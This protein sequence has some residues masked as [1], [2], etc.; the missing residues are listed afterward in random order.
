VFNRGTGV[1]YNVTFPGGP[2]LDPPPNYSIDYLRVH[3]NDVTFA[4]N[5]SAS[6]SAPSLTVANGGVSIVV[7]ENAGDVAILTT[8]LSSLSATQ[9][10]IGRAAGANGTL[11]VTAGTFSLIHPLEVGY[12]GTGTLNITGGSVSDSTGYIGRFTG[13]TG[14]ATVSGAAST[15]TNSDEIQV[16]VDGTGTLRI[17]AGGS[18]TD[19]YGYVGL[20]PGSMGAATVTGAGSSWT[21]TEDFY[22]GYRGTGTLTI[23]AGGSVSDVFGVVGYDLGS[24]GTATVTGAGS[25]WTNSLALIVDYS[26]TLRIEAGGSVSS[27][28]GEVR[29]GA[30]ATVN[31]IGSTWTNSGNLT[32]GN[33][34]TGTLTIEAGGSVSNQDGRVGKALFFTGTVTVSGIGST[35]TNSG[36]LAVGDSGRGTLTIE[37]GGSVSNQDGYVG[38]FESSTGTATVTG[39][40]ST[41]TNSGSLTVGRFGTGTLR[42]E[43]GGS[44][45][46]INSVIA[47]SGTSSAGTV[48]VTGVG[49]T[50][51]T[52]G[53]LSVGS[54]S[55]ADG[56]GSL[57]VETG[58]MVNIVQNLVLRSTGMVNLHGGQI[59]LTSSGSELIFSGGAFNFSLGTLRFATSQAI[60]F[61]SSI[62][63]ALGGEPRLRVGQHLE[64]DGTL[65]LDAPFQIDGGHLEV[66]SLA[67]NSDLLFTAGVLEVRGGSITGSTSLVVPASG[68]LRTSGVHSF[69]VTG[70]AGSTIT[71]TGNL[72]LGDAAAVNGFGTQGTVQVGANTLTLLDA[73]DVVFDSLALATLGSGAS[74]GAL[75]AANGLTLD[76]GG[77]I[78]G[79]G[80]VSTPN[81]AV[82][83]LINNGHITGNSP[84]QPITLPGYVKGVGTL[85]NVNLTGTF[86]PG[87]SPTT[88]MV[89]NLAFAPTST[90]IMEIGG[91]SAGSQYDQLIAFGN[92]FFDGNLQISLINGF[93]PALG[94]AFNIFDWQ[95][96]SGTFDTINLPTLSSSLA[97]DTSQLYI[98]GTLRIAS[99]DLPGDF[100]H[101]GKVD[102]ADY[103]AWR[104]TGIDGQDGCNTW[105]A[106][107][108]AT[109]NSGSG[110]V[111]SA[112]LYGPEV[113]E[114]ASIFL[115]ASFAAVGVLRH[116]Q[117]QCR[118]Y[119]P[120]SC[121]VGAIG[122]PT[123]GSFIALRTKILSST[124]QPSRQEQAAREQQE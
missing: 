28:G 45:S 97:W 82:K 5:S 113:P 83:P 55:P 84:T 11:N 50:W 91:T 27:Q 31:G 101:D 111:N 75:S 44:V 47:G 77:N 76:F 1:A 81:N 51:S 119:A 67:V 36:N 68:E 18:A 7:G 15:W 108:G 102:A 93:V 57:T 103:V 106:N 86:S 56:V 88:S 120:R 12:S 60:G 54:N 22:V 39:A 59:N 116:R 52:S 65:T 30:A 21:N 46:S 41:W 61:G 23:E 62:V 90:L 107:F 121:P 35:W 66:D 4:D 3:S 6:V 94:N 112:N 17:E 87:L 9:A 89:G 95:S 70:L 29:R 78:T 42:I 16:G 26:G 122:H 118:H 14:T 73:N 115:F 40:G 53:S 38:N 99:A 92:L 32:V 69:R 80:T 64:I 25:T 58:A 105:R 34:G 8:S 79:F 48:T 33:F 100:N 63:Q 2:I 110:V 19:R 109:L 85:D 13:S 43:N 74:P 104:K 117:A 72:T 10:S 24:N 98:D 49:S 114:P 20:N 37:A 96:A 124:F 123:V 71:A